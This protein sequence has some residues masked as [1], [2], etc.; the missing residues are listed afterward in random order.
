M[1]MNEKR[2]IDFMTDNLQRICAEATVFLLWLDRWA[3]NGLDLQ[4]LFFVYYFDYADGGGGPHGRH[5]RNGVL[6]SPE[7]RHGFDDRDLHRGCELCALHLRGD[8]ALCGL[9]AGGEL[10]RS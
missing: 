6:R 10:N 7:S 8:R 3:S 5:N 4:R 9:S 2:A 1:A